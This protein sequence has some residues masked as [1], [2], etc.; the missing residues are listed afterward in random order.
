MVVKLSQV[1]FGVKVSELCCF[2]IKVA[3]RNQPELAEEES[4]AGASR[5]GSLRKGKP[6]ARNMSVT[7][8]CHCATDLHGHRP[9]D[10]LH[11]SMGS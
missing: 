7:A 8:P 4:L 1:R 5:R 3:L 2:R 9:G 11:T 6:R 10:L